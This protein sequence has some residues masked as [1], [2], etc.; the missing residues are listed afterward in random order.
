MF[1]GLKIGNK[2][3]CSSKLEYLPNYNELLKFMVNIS[4]TQ[5]QFRQR[6]SPKAV[7]T[8][9]PKTTK[10]IALTH[11][12][13]SKSK[14]LNA[15][16][17]STQLGEFVDGDH[18][19]QVRWLSFKGPWEWRSPSTLQ[20]VIDNFRGIKL[21]R[22][23]SKVFGFFLAAG[24][25]GH[26][27]T[28]ISLYKHATKSV[29]VSVDVNEYIHIYS[30]Y[31]YKIWQYDS[32][33]SVAWTGFQYLIPRFTPRLSSNTF[34]P[35]S[36]VSFLLWFPTYTNICLVQFQ[37]ATPSLQMSGS[38]WE[39]PPFAKSLTFGRVRSESL[40]CAMIVE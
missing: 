21:S 33:C 19:S 38:L 16:G 2:K 11:H 35:L 13:I 18:H 36:L 3:T 22:R 1:G 6:M 28:I 10:F 7:E 17:E 4:D 40:R 25:G 15:K 8:L 34:S 30:L 9:I 32:S 37:N 5:L 27:L 20:V 14:S 26:R 12:W 23:S 31:R 24:G 39:S 29:H